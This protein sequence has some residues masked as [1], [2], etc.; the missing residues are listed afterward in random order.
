MSR[1]QPATQTTAVAA[2]AL[3]RGADPL[4]LAAYEYWERIGSVGQWLALPPDTPEPIA[5]LYR[6][7]LTETF[8]DPAYM[9][10]TAKVVTDGSAMSAADLEK[11]VHELDQT[12]QE[13]FEYLRQL[14]RKVGFT[15]ME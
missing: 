15:Q 9:E 13:I 4:G 10:Q 6:S 14:Q 8:K 3:V 12:P 11:L 7:A 5:A 1:C 2:A